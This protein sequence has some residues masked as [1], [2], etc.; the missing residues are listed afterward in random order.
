MNCSQRL[1]SLT[2][3]PVSNRV[4]THFSTVLVSSVNKGLWVRLITYNLVNMNLAEA[5]AGLARK[6]VEKKQ[7]NEDIMRLEVGNLR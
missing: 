3:F 2:N 7:A 4:G 1:S 5:A 6:E